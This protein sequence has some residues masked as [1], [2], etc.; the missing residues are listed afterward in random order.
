[1]TREMKS[2]FSLLMWAIIL[3]F[4]VVVISFPKWI[5]V[6]YPLPHRDIVFT[7]AK[8]YNVDP[9]LVFA[10]IRAESKYQTAAESP[11]GAKGLMQIMPDTA[12]WIAEQMKIE[13]FKTDDLHKPEVNIRF[14][15]WYIKNLNTEFKGSLPL[16]VAAYN[17]GRGKV[18]QWV[19]EGKWDGNSRNIEGIPFLET[20]QYVKNV[21]KNYEAYKAIY[22]Q[23]R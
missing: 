23:V 7:T 9:Y 14:G 19:Q 6:F 8:E 11:V 3:I 17:A 22:D 10:I 2:K 20:K 5:T 21:L 1:M 18:K 15:C 13:N 4:L 12:Q 16:Q